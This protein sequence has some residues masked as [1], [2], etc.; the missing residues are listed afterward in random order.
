MSV[1]EDLDDSLD[2]RLTEIKKVWNKLNR[3]SHRTI[4]KVRLLIHLSRNIMKKYKIIGQSLEL[5]EVN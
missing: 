4:Q 5:K 1:G 2:K 3:S